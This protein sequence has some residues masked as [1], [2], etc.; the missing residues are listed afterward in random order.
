MACRCGRCG[1]QPLHGPDG[2]G[3]TGAEGQDQVSL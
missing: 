1:G 2:Q 3:Y